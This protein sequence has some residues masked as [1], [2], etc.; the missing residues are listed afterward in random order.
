MTLDMKTDRNNRFSRGAT[1]SVWCSLLLAGAVV[2]SLPIVSRFSGG[3]VLA[4]LA[5]ASIL[6][7]YIIALAILLSFWAPQHVQK[8]ARIVWIVA[9]VACLLFSVFIL[10]G[11]AIDA[12][13][14][15]DT[16]LVLSLSGL[17]FPSS[18]LGIFGGAFYSFVRAEHYGNAL[19]LIAV[20][21]I[22]AG[23]GF[24]QWFVAV[25]LVIHQ[26]RSWRRRPN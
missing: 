17:S 13:Q 2:I 15:A 19:D 9:A 23:V 21:V 1:I 11:G 12:M 7:G 16:A 4:G 18:F 25:P 6:A 26:V 22:F 10:S 24:L 8:V 20:W 5:S 14:A 3:T